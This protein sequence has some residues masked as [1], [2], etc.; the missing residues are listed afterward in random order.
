MCKADGFLANGEAEEPHAARQPILLSDAGAAPNEAA[1]V[2]LADGRWREEAVR[3]DRAM[4]LFG[5]DATDAARKL[6]QE[7][8]GR[9]GVEP[10]IFKQDAQGRWREGA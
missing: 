7:L 2:L 6:W 9:D 3:F 8:K 4:L 5:E 1:M 10:R